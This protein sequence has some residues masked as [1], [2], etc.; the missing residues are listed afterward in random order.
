MSE[1][2]SEAVLLGMDLGLLEYLL[3]LEKQQ[4]T[5]GLAINIIT[6]AQ[7]REQE[8]QARR[9]EELDAWDEAQPIPAEH[10]QE[11][12]HLMHAKPVHLLLP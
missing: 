1:H 10:E 8:D 12:G 7:A 2:L 11:V 4:R 6:R 9:D 3:Q 5:Q